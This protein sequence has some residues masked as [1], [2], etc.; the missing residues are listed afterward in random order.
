MRVNNPPPAVF[1]DRPLFRGC[2]PGVTRTLDLRIRNPLLYPAEL[3]AHSA[4][5]RCRYRPCDATSPHRSKANEIDRVC[6]LLLQRRNNW[7]FELPRTS[8]TLLA[9]RQI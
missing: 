8:E 3:R 5:R 7:N 2:A 6:V 4:E 1:C 9:T